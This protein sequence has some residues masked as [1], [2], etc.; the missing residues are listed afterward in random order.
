MKYCVLIPGGMADRPV[1]SLGGKTP[2]E[3]ASTPNMDRIS[4]LGRLGTLQTIPGG[5]EPDSDVALM[6]ILG[7]DPVRHACGCGPLEAAALGVELGPG[8]VAFRCDLVTAADGRMIDYT[9]GHITSAEGAALVGVLNERL[10]TPEIFFHAG[11][12]SRHLMVYRGRENI[13]ARCTPPYE[14]MGGE[15]RK[16]FPEGPGTKLLRDLIERSAAVLEG[17]DINAVRVDH[18]ENPA[19]MIWLWGGGKA[20]SLQPFADQFGRS[21]ALVSNVNMAK[22]LG[23]HLGLRVIEVEGDAGRPDVNYDGQADAALRALYEVDLAVVYVAAIDE[24]SHA[25]TAAEKVLAIESVDRAMVGRILDAMSDRDDFRILVA[26]GQMT[27][28]DERTHLSDPVPFA[29]CGAGIVSVRELPFSE[30]TAAITGL[31]IDHG[32]ELMAY[33][34][35]D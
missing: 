33:F 13:S 4:T 29:M 24:V 9:A 30:K 8:A 1:D 31:E 28:V 16:R 26:P 25:G 2:L 10:G 7:T 3:A 32:H 34:L 15:F 17:H 12:D 6:S 18:G 19:T 23:R 21:G 5:M 27:G 22:G 20:P 35:R 11:V 14:F